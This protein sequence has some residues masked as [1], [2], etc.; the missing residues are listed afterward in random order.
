MF[1]FRNQRASPATWLNTGQPEIS[2]KFTGRCRPIFG[3]LSSQSLSLM[4]FRQKCF[5][6]IRVISCSMYHIVIYCCS[7]IL[8]KHASQLPNFDCFLPY[9]LNILHLFLLQFLLFLLNIH[10][11]FE[12]FRNL[13]FG[14]FTLGPLHFIKFNHFFG[15]GRQGK[16]GVVK[17]IRRFFRIIIVNT[18][19]IWL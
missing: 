3:N 11:N 18:I 9:I 2:L 17:L 12:R 14:E 7:K 10:T 6:A 1:Y 13:F 5:V 4:I 8:R 15:G 16:F 19:Q